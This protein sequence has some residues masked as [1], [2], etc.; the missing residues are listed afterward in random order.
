[1]KMWKPLG[2][3]VQGTI[4]KENNIECQD[5][6]ASY[7]KNGISVI[8]LADGASVKEY[9]LEG[10]N[11]VAPAV[12][13]FVATNFVKLFTGEDAYEVKR[14][15][16]EDLINRIAKRAKKLKTDIHEF[17]STLIFI[18][19]KEDKQCIIG[20]I[21]D[22]IVC[23][24][25]ENGWSIISKEESKNIL[26]ETDLVTGLN[27]YARMKLIR[28]DIN[29][30]SSFAILSNGC[31][32]AIANDGLANVESFAN[33]VKENK[34]E[35][36]VEVITNTIVHIQEEKSTGDCGVVFLNK[37]K[38]VGIYEDL[39]YEEKQE[40]FE[41]H[42]THLYNVEAAIE[43]ASFIIKVLKTTNANVQ[44]ISKRSK[45]SLATCKKITSI[46]NKANYLSLNDDVYSLVKT[47]DINE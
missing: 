30:S 3:S 17:A 13:K 1:M 7:V 21:G 43:D 44:Y 14:I 33:F 46:L 38:Q 27:V 20:H 4:N 41:K 2:V 32:D 12:C 6:I 10:A 40:I 39:E 11:I 8:A 37:V 18:A 31:E 47:E 35:E 24:E 34:A 19:I 9:S 45:V 28:E 25:D 36:A 29:S 5:I 26:N 22:G 16:L 23:R 42:Y 15:I